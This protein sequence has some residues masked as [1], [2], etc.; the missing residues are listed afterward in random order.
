MGMNIGETQEEYDL[1]RAEQG[2]DQ[3]IDFNRRAVIGKPEPIGNGRCQH[4]HGSLIIHTMPNGEVWLQC[5]RCALTISDQKK[6]W[7]IL[8]PD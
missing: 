7:K 1:W 5:L 2:F 4:P 8:W 3:T 6:V